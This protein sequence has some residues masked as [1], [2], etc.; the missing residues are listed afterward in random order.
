MKRLLCLLLCVM[1][2]ASLVSCNDE[3]SEPVQTET[4]AESGEASQDTEPAA[5]PEEPKEMLELVVDEMS[6]YEIVYPAAANSQETYAV[7]M[8]SELFKSKTGVELLTKDDALAPGKTHEGETCKIIIG[9]T[10]YAQS[11]TAYDT[12]MY[13]DF[14]IIAED[15]NIVI[16]AYTNTG[17][18]SAVRWLKKNVFASFADGD[19]YM[20]A[21]DIQD[22]EVRG[23]AV[24][25]WEINGNVPLHYTIIYPDAELEEAALELRELIAKKTGCYMEVGLDEKTPVSDREIL[26][27]DT[28]REE[29]D[30][31]ECPR[32][33][34]YIVKT[35]ANK[36]VVK[37]FGLHSRL[38]LNESLFECIIGD[39]DELIMDGTYERIGN[40]YDDPHD[41]SEPEDTDVRIMCANLMADRRGYDNGALADHGFLFERR[42]EIFYAHLDYYQPTVV[43]FQEACVNWYTAMDNY[44]EAD[45]WEVLKVK[46]PTNAQGHNI[47]SSLM[48]RK[49]IY[50]LIDSGAHLYTQTNNTNCRWYAWAILENKTTKDRFCVVS[51]HWD[52]ADT[53]YTMKQ[54][55][56]ITT[57]VNDT[58]KNKGIPVF[59]MGDFN[60]NEWSKAWQKYFPGINSYD[61]MKADNSL[62]VNGEDSWHGWGTADTAVGGSCDHITAT[63]SDVE[64]LKFET[65]VYLDQIWASD[66]S[67]LL[68][69]FKFK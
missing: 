56:E 51:T 65:L 64:I 69:D 30:G 49:D 67:W 55:E 18:S 66:H 45:K 28:N 23:Y 39:A 35:C 40:F 59:T 15:S 36:L 58:V 32:A 61:C 21:I 4:A 16:A 2:L 47:F 17:Y 31:V 9:R 42:I 12:L 52:G 46:N 24:E 68:C 3:A 8:I 7:E 43:G 22:S 27:G 33:L 41:T 26:I 62:R 53:D 63:K 14:R 10:N 48:W 38:K 1:L 44:Y 19:L 11:E 60:S 20:E 29:S 54:V 25:K 50:N 34:S 13:Q 5:E 57:F 6:N 37:A